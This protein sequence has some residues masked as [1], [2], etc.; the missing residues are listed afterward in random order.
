MNIPCEAGLNRRDFLGRIIPACAVTCLG[1]KALP[2]FGQTA[3]PSAQPPAGHKFDAEV[4]RKFTYR[5]AASA[6]FNAAFIPFIKFCAQE[7]GREKTIEMLKAFVSEG[8]VEGAKRVA[9][10]LGKNDFEA[11]KSFFS[12]SSPAYAN[13]LTFTLPES[14]DKVHELKVTECLYAKIFLDA[15]VGDLGYAGVCFGDYA[16]ARS[17]NPQIEMVRDKTLMQGDPFC[18]HRYL[19]KG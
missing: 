3:V 11:L 15:G 16:F 13:T 8:S 19:W 2:L 5:Q 12:P 9:Q 1:L 7:L 18:N 10:R 14:T 6:Q 17:F 4:P